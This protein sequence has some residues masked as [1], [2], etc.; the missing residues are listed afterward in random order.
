MG[1]LSVI[2]AARRA[3]HSSKAGINIASHNIANA[4][5]PGY[6]R[7]RVELR[8]T[9]V[10][11]SGNVLVNSGV[12]I[13]D[14]TQIKDRFI[15]AEIRN[16]VNMI[17]GYEVKNEV[18]SRIEALI[19]EPSETGLGQLFEQFFNAFDDLA[20]N[21]ED[22]AIRST[23]VQAGIAL[24]RR[25]NDIFNGIMRIKNDVLNEL[26]A[27]VKNVNEILSK[28]AKLNLEAIRLYSS[29]KGTADIR[30]KI[31]VELKELSKL[32]NIKV[33]EEE[34][35]AVRVSISGILVVNRGSV[36]SLEIRFSDGEVRIT[37]QTGEIKPASGEIYSWQSAFNDMIPGIIDKFNE[38]ARNLI[39]E[40]NNYHKIGYGLKGSSSNSAPTGYE[41]FAGSGAGS[42]QVNQDII[43]DINRISAS[44][45]GDSG[46]NEVAL[47]IAGLRNSDKI[48]KVY[49]EI[50]TDIGIQSRLSR[51]NVELHRMILSQ[52]ESQR[53]SISGVSL[54][55]EMVN[56]IKFQ[57]AFDAAAKVV[58]SVNEMFDTLLTMVG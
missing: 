15:E 22:R 38:L 10:I 27:K 25:F 31:Y 16:T 32:V 47:A 37:S 56:L 23:V 30:D 12:K 44:I 46:N 43:D 49:D 28:I 34:S 2:E 14:V 40:V 3:L 7:Q 8:G 21:P 24:S 6:T 29:G 53:E 58:Q 35:G 1:L 51:D 20:K 19:N 50:I 45:D 17:G 57:K 54:D 13:V 5:T 39:S 11:T 36:N 55:E 52:L 48:I 33:V 18:L 4:N 9:D 26:Q 42:I 41:F